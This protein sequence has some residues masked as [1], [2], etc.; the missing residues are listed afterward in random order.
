MAE[1]G[2]KVPLKPQNIFFAKINLC[3]LKHIAAFFNPN[4]DFL[5]DCK[6][7]EI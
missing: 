6:S 7:Y 4:I 2:L 3:R 5:I 1:V